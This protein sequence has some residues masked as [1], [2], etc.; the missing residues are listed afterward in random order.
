MPE[1]RVDDGLPTLVMRRQSRIDYH[2][3]RNFVGPAVSCSCANH[4][5][6]RRENPVRLFKVARDSTS[7]ARLIRNE[8]RDSA[9]KDERPISRVSDYYSCACC[10]ASCTRVASSCSSA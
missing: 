9:S 2:A 3:F 1:V 4:L 7:S 10:L 6:S 5:A 8:R